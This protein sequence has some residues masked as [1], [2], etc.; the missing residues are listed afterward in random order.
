MTDL[1]P[2]CFSHDNS[3]CLLKYVCTSFP[4][5]NTCFG[6]KRCPIE[7][8]RIRKCPKVTI[9]SSPMS[10]GDTS[11]QAKKRFVFRQSFKTANLL[12]RL[13]F[14]KE[15]YIVNVLCKMCGYFR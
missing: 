2:E 12:F 10:T 8:D 4:I 5:K 7:R 9:V 13:F 14:N 1:M 6:K 15:A 3:N 11:V